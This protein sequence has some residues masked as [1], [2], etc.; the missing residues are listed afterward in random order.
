MTTSPP[1]T[2]PQRLLSLDVARGLTMMLMVIVNNPGSWEHIYPPLEHAAWNGFTPT[3]FVFPNFLFLV[4]V[5]I[6]F[7]LSRKRDQHIERGPIMRAALK[8][9]LILIGIGLFITLYV[10]D[11]DVA[12]LRYPGVLQRIGLVYFICCGLYLYLHDRA[13]WAVALALLVLYYLILTLTP[14]PGVGSPDLMVPTANIGAW[15]DRQL[16]TEA[17]L[18]RLTRTWDPEGLLST[19][20]AISTGLFGVLTGITLK[21]EIGPI[22]KVRHLFVL[23]VLLIVA[24]LLANL[25]MPINKNLWTSSYT[26]FAGGL[27]MVLLTVTYWL[28]DVRGIKGWT[29]WPVVFGVNSIFAY[30][31]SELFPT[32]LHQ[33]RVGESGSLFEWLY[34]NGFAQHFADERNASLACA[35]ALVLVMTPMLWVMYRR[36]IFVK[37]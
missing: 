30:V 13:L 34:Q 29:T 10:I 17:H 33:V 18:Y 7:A 35:L 31:F 21:R 32:V 15:L 36:R 37:I 2:V 20:P 12:N 25:V 26:L 24:G 8:R 16:F 3:D 11:F 4:G 6:V 1:P 19:L 9:T 27:S 22:Q 23:G 28:V 14:V 5:A